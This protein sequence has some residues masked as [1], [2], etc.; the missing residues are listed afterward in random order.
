MTRER[1]AMRRRWRQ[2]TGSRQQCVP[3]LGPQLERSQQQRP[4]RAHRRL[5]LTRVKVLAPEAVAVA[6]RGA[7]QSRQRARQQ[8]RHR[9]ARRA[10]ALAAVVVDVAVRCGTAEAA[11]TGQPHYGLI[12]L[13]TH[14]HRRVRTA[15][16]GS[17]SGV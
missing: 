13:K 2:Q 8:L 7:R 3:V 14:Q 16:R 5:H 6:R 12:K 15:A 4:S 11:A 9:A 17:G 10:R 1:A